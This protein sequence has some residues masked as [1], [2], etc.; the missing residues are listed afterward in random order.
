M[1]EQLHGGGLESTLSLAAR[2]REIS[3]AEGFGDHADSASP[4]AR[5]PSCSIHGSS[6]ASPSP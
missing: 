2:G 5:D 6:F 3:R 4:G 1:G